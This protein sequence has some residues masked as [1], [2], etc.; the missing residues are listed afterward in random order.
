MF[1]LG[2]RRTY[3]RVEEVDHHYKSSPSSQT[4]SVQLGY[5]EHGEEPTFTT[6]QDLDV[7]AAGPYVTGHRQSGRLFS[8]KKTGTNTDEIIYRGSVAGV[9]VDGVR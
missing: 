1:Q 4:V 2:S 9:E 5:S 8:L 7:G 3:K 6:A